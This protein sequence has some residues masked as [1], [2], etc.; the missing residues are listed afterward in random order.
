[1][2]VFG[3]RAFGVDQNRFASFHGF[4]GFYCGQACTRCPAFD[5]DLFSAFDDDAKHWG[6]LDGVFNKKSGDAIVIPE[7]AGDCQWVGP[8]NVIR[9][10]D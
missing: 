7:K 10:D 5:G 9:G 6:F 4:D 8:R 2:G 1:L 3:D